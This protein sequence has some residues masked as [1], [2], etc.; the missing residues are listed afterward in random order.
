MSAGISVGPPSLAPSGLVYAFM[1]RRSTTPVNSCSAPIGSATATQEPDS[2]SWIW[3]SAR[4]KSA[5]SRSSMF[6]STTRARPPSSARRHTRPVP[7]STPITALT[8][9][10]APSVTVNAAIASP[11]NPASPGVSRRLI[12]R[13]CQSAWQTDAERV[14]CRLCSSSSQSATVVPD[15]TV[16]RRLTPPDWKSIAS[17]SDVFPVPRWPTTATLRI[18]PGSV[19]AIAGN[20]LLG[21]ISASL[22][23]PWP[24][25][26]GGAWSVGGEWPRLHAGEARAQAQNG[27][28]VE[29]GD[30]RLGHAEHIADLPQGQL[31][32]VVESD[33]DLLALGQRRDRL[34]QRLA[35][36]GLVQRGLGLGPFRVLDRV[37]EGDLVA[38]RGRDRPD[39][40]E[41]RDRRAR[42]VREAVLELLL[43]DPDLLGDLLVRRR[44]VELRLER[45]HSA[46]DLSRAGAHGARHP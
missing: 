7:T 38:A 9:T 39:L 45:C 10:S 34:G 28:R 1:C 37:D 6:T 40:V 33:H 4:K 2:C 14:I 36:L 29:L 26:A 24:S 42:D 5:R 19:T 32:V 27:L 25:L 22:S 31:L 3:P 12:F 44:P 8:T 16:P 23:A 18:F 13:P 41:R 46:L 17:T 21:T 35:R 11:W 15:S 30:P 20:H 43:G